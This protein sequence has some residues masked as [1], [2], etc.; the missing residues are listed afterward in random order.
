[1]TEKTLL[2]QALSQNGSL[3]EFGTHDDFWVP[4]E[5]DM[6]QKYLQRNRLWR[7]TRRA[8]EKPCD[9]ATVAHF[10]VGLAQN[11]PVVGATSIFELLCQHSDEINQCG[12][13]TTL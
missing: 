4:E 12:T 9:S 8:I 1:M 7:Q 3:C 6:V 13:M 2:L 11:E 5:H 10:V